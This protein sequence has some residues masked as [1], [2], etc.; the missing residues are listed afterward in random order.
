[1][2]CWSDPDRVKA[3]RDWVSIRPSMCSHPSLRGKTVDNDYHP[4]KPSQP[5]PLKPKKV[6]LYRE[7]WRTI[8]DNGFDVIPLRGREG[9]FTGWPYQLNDDLRS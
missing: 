7:V 1:M 4:E 5:T 3:G 9:P 2:R 6:T 8:R